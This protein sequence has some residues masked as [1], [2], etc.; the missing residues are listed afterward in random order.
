MAQPAPAVWRMLSGDCPPDSWRNVMPDAVAI[1]VNRGV[2]RAAVARPAGRL[3]RTL[4]WCPRQPIA[5]NREEPQRTQRTRRTQREGRRETKVPLRQSHF[6]VFRSPF[7]SFVS[8]CSLW[9]FPFAP[10]LIFAFSHF[11]R[12]GFAQRCSPG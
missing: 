6:T 11:L 12:A 8:S 5:P 10:S 2:S 4:G 3:P 1:S 7:V 9:F